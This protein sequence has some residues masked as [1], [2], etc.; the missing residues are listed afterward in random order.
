MIAAGVNVN[1]ANAK[2]STALMEASRVRD[3]T[4]V[5]QLIAAGVHVNNSAHYRRRTPLMYAARWGQAAITAS[6]LDEGANVF[7]VDTAGRTALSHLL[8]GCSFVFYPE[9]SMP[10]K[11]A[12][13]LP[14]IDTLTLS[15][16]E[17]VTIKNEEIAPVIKALGGPTEA[18]I[19]GEAV[20]ASRAR[21][22]RDAAVG[23]WAAAHPRKEDSGDGAITKPT[24][25]LKG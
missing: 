20:I 5:A 6:L 25:Y 9:R 10:M 14:V 11:R 22:R 7:A 21:T 2:G 12:S 4:V 16:A 1:V 8:E 19:T 17:S 18:I 23:F 24:Q 3:R 15:I 13:K